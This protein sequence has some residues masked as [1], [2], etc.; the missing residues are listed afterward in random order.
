MG[1]RVTLR[2]VGFIVLDGSGNGTAKIGPL[3]ALETWYPE[4]V[5]VKV[6]PN[7]ANEAACTISV[8][9]QN[10]KSFRD[11]TVSGSSGDSTGKASGDRLVK[12]DHVW[13]DWTGGDPG[14]RATITVMG[15]KEIG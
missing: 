15:T 11:Y 5:A 12:G 2:E 9:D 6:N 4:T 14:Q 7:P 1:K 13:A 3:T 8:G 10:T